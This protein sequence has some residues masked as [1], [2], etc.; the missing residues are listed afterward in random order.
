MNYLHI[1]IYVLLLEQM[2]GESKLISYIYGKCE[3]ICE[4]YIIV[5]NNG[6]GYRVFASYYT[7]QK[8]SLH[9]EIKVFTYMNVREDAINLYGFLSMEELDIF[10]LLLNVSGVGPKLALAITNE[11]TPNE[12]IL[13]ITSEDLKTL[14]QCSGVGKKTAQRMILDLKDKMQSISLS[15]NSVNLEIIK[16][17][18][19]TNYRQEAMEAL[20]TLGY[21]KSESMQVVMEVSETDM[22][23]SEILKLSLKKLSKK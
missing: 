16:N 12:I 20:V 22:E 3:F 13:S 17:L 23:V 14:T 11:L 7:I 5:S 8:V 2:K 18:D 1:I 9:N 4:K 19:T 15:D 21:S 6:I 10:N